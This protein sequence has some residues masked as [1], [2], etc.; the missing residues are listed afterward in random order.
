MLLMWL[1]FQ[2]WCKFYEIVSSFDLL[3]PGDVQSSLHLCE[4]PGAFVTALNHF[5]HI[6]R[7]DLQVLSYKIQNCS[8]MH[9]SIC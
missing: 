4:A 9:M 8:H 2:A 6:Q 1:M 7:P 3:P 5:I